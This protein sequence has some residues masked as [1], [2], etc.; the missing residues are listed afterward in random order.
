MATF[1]K[2]WQLG[3]YEKNIKMIVCEKINYYYNRK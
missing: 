3:C 1:R 2:C